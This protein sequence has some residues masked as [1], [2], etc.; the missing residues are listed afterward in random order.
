MFLVRGFTLPGAWNGVKFYILPD[1]QKL[2]QPEVSIAVY[3][4]V[5][6]RTH[7]HDSVYDSF[8]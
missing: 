4:H 2:L 1:W 7:T 8:L 5:H 6:V 3:V